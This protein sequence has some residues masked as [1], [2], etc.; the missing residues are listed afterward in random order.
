MV[1]FGN[2]NV[3]ESMRLGKE[4]AEYVSAQFTSPIKLEF[5]KVYM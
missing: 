3:A 5:E 1:K 2:D 4:A